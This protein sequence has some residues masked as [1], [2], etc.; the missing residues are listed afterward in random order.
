MN[1]KKDFVPQKD[2]QNLSE[3][4]CKDKKIKDL[5]I[6]DKEFDICVV[7]EEKE[8]DNFIA[9][10]GFQKFV[11]F[12][13]DKDIQEQLSLRQELCLKLST[14]K[15]GTCNSK[16]GKAYGCVVQKNLFTKDSC[17][18]DQKIINE[19]TNYNEFCIISDCR[20]RRRKG[21][22][23]CT[24]HLNEFK[25]MIQI[26]EISY[27]NLK[28]VK[29]EKEK[30]KYLKDFFDIHQ[31]I[32]DIYHDFLLDKP[33]LIEKINSML[34]E[35]ENEY[36]TQ[37]CQAYN[38]KTCINIED[39][40]K[41]KQR[42]VNRGKEYS[43]GYFCK[44]H[45]K[46]YSE[47]KKAFNKFKTNLDQILDNNLLKTNIKNTK[48]FYKMIEYCNLGEASKLK[49]ELLSTIDVTQELNTY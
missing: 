39:G 21:Y 3:K 48:D 10:K 46:C 40:N 44:I 2:C 4:S 13:E 8:L 36:G 37:N 14:G 18:L 35:V 32:G 16:L 19:Y 11:K 43:Q 27:N 12:D 33:E 38:I 9:N 5:C 22:N 34:I 31:I 15:G 42:C 25:E 17:V 45:L 30:N 41:L 7:N 24:F 26:L 6:Y 1:R 23:I 20:R 28:Y 49:Y 47:R 29:N